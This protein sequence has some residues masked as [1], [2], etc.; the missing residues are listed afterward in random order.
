MSEN[1]TNPVIVVARKDGRGGIEPFGTFSKAQAGAKVQIGDKSYTVTKDGRVN[2]P[3]F[4]MDTGIKGTDGRMRLAIGFRTEKGGD[5]WKQVK[6]ITLKPDI[7]NGSSVKGDRIKSLPT[8]NQEDKERGV[9][10]PKD[11]MDYNWSP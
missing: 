4:I 7:L 6:A 1:Y 11:S 9:L 5:G 10:T 2:I 3:K 8:S